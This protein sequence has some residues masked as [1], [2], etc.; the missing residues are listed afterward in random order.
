MK[1]LVVLL[2]L[3]TVTPAHAG[4]FEMPVRKLFQAIARKK[5]DRVFHGVGQA[6]RATIKNEDGSVSDAIVRVSR[7]GA[8]KPGKPDILG[9]AIKKKMASGVDQ[10][11][12]LVTSKGTGAIKRRLA[13]FAG[14]FAGQ[15]MSSL[16]SFKIDGP[17]G[18]IT[19]QLPEDFKTPIDLNPQGA[20]AQRPSFRL[21][22]S[23]GGIFT[24]AKQSPIYED[25]TV[26]F[27]QPLTAEEAKD[28]RFTP[29]HDGDSVQPVGLINRLRKPAYK[30]SQTG[31]GLTEEK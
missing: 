23:R 10:D 14:D 26:H 31:R 4:I 29:W 19:T 27:D 1:K 18:A 20:M 3:L 11:F 15:S 2:A 22:L 12:L 30:G 21:A 16:T 6:Y 8:S 24:K 28:L 25:V 5:N 17:R 13:K 7:G 9:L